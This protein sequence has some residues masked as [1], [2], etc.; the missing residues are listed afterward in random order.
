MPGAVDGG[1]EAERS[2][3]GVGG[4][5]A[6]RNRRGDARLARCVSGE[7]VVERGDY[8]SR[9]RDDDPGSA[10]GPE[11]S[12]ADAL[13]LLVLVRRVAAGY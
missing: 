5:I 6:R 9:R 4:E 3:E 7:A 11:A 1:P 13:M 12:S 8:T 2:V 10:V